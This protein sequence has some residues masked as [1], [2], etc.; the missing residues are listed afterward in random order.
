MLFSKI[1]IKNEL[2][3]HRS[4]ETILK[5]VNELL[6]SEI[7]KERDIINRLKRNNP[8]QNLTISVEDK[9]NVFSL[10][11]I[12]FICVRYR[13]RFLESSHFKAQYP[14]PALMQIKAFEKKYDA[15]IE[16]FR[17][18]APAEAFELE[19]INKDPLLF[20]QLNEHQYYLLHQ[21]GHDLKWYRRIL[22]WP[23]QNLKSLLLTL[24][25]VGSVFSF[26][27]P[28]SVMNVFSF[29]SSMYLRIWLSIHTFIA[30]TGFALWMGL[31][32][33]KSLSEMNWSSKY[34][35]Y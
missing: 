35:N 19:N 20:A 2:I 1:N 21:W 32:F 14:H 5:Q 33:D 16:S 25:M 6:S 34:Y 18:I 22:A 17:I 8:D 12:K 13:L 29:Q 28:D 7:N 11:D 4:Q 30:L 26:S 24:F 15:T 31:A 3:R 23:L 9:E 27:L 10:E